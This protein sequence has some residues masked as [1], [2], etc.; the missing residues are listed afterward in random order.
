MATDDAAG[1]APD[2]EAAAGATLPCTACGAELR[3]APGAGRLRCEFCG[4]EQVIDAVETRPVEHDLVERL[5]TLA[6]TRRSAAPATPGRETSCQGCGAVTTFGEHQTAG[7][8]A[9]CGSALVLD[10]PADPAAIAP[11]FLVPFAVTGKAAAERFRRWL[12]GLWFR[13][14][15]LRSRHSIEELRSVY[16]PFFTFDMHAASRWSAQSGTYYWTTETYTAMVNGRPAT[17]T[18]SVRRVR[19]WPSSGRR[20]DDFDDVLVA[21]SRGLPAGAAA[22]IYPFRLGE[23]VPT[24]PGWLAGFGA[25][26]H[27]V[28]LESC[29]EAAVTTVRS[30]CRNRCSGDVPGDTH[31]FLSVTTRVSDPTFKPLLLPIHVLAYRWKGRPFR[32]L[33][34]GQTG[35]VAGDAPWSALKISLAILALLIAAL[36]AYWFLAN[37]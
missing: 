34:N 19:W 20:E 11:E 9:F 13:P 5:R 30:E 25:E 15:A 26:R 4:H 17:R 22:R 35:A 2:A 27:S 16:L 7:R 3:Y 12:R 18:R 24:G 32:V 31:R 6:E 28:D 21:A 37:R 29:F 36:A 23:L 10:P 14:S 33:V 1:E 8:C